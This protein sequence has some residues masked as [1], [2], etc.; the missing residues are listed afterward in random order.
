MPVYAD[1]LFVINGFINYL[2]LLLARKFLKV[3]TSRL[4][5]LFGAAAGSIFSLKI[6]L[7]PLNTFL[8]TFIRILFALIIVIVSFKI[9]SIKK[10]I[11]HFFCFLTVNCC[12]SGIIIA[13]IYFVNPP[14]LIYNNGIYYYNISFIKTICLSVICFV[15]ISLAEKILRK[16]TIDNYIYNTTVFLNNK[17]VSGEGFADTGNNLREPFSSNPVIIADQKVIRSIFPEATD[18]NSIKK[19]IDLYINNKI[20]LI[21]IKTLN[22]ENILPAFKSDKIILNS[23]TGIK[24]FSDVFVAISDKELFNGEFDFILNNSILEVE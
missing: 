8:E 17:A 12:F 22:G 19:D 20:R 11:K 2:L 18:I 24:E 7:P 10:L 9:N 5:M 13:V 15:V 3:Q 14:D 6:F 4:R 1:V 23:S 16:K 21:P